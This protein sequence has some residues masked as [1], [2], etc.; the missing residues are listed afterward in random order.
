[1]APLRIILLT[2]LYA[3]LLD[4]LAAVL[5]TYIRSGKGPEIVFK[6]ISSALL[7][8]SAFA[9]GAGMIALG[10]ALHMVIA[11]I[12]A[13]LFFLI[14][15]AFPPRRQAA[16]AWIIP[17]TLYG[18]VVWLLMNLVVLR[19]TR[20]TQGSFTTSGVII[21]TLVLIFCIGIPIAWSAHR[22]Y[23]RHQP[24]KL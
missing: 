1:M 20:V 23:I 17:G 5:V 2:G 6:Y 12:W 19:L 11:L 10:I 4:G 14:C 15:A 24:T 16:A 22:Y 13:T 3:G 9:G 7:G 21:G 18:I 8:P